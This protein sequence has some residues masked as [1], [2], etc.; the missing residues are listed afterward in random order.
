M[1]LPEIGECTGYVV[2]YRAWAFRSGRLTSIVKF[3]YQTEWSPGV[4]VE[5]NDRIKDHPFA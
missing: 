4:V 2:G 1:R 5:A 3:K